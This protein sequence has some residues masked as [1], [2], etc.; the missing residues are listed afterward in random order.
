MIKARQSTQSL[1]VSDLSKFLGPRL[2]SAAAAGSRRQ[3]RW[4]RSPPSIFRTVENLGGAK[5]SNFNEL[6]VF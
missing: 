4:A 1:C 3:R 2:A 6:H 5:P